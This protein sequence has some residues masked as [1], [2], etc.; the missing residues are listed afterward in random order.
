MTVCVVGLGKI[1]LPLSLQVAGAGKRVI[2]ADR[3]PRVVG[4]VLESR[5]PFPGE[6]GLAERLSDAVQGGLL[7]ATTDTAAAVAE[8]N[9]VIV[10]VPLVIG[11]DF[12]PDFGALDG[13]TSDVARGMRPGT[14]VSY[15]TT[16]P[17]GTT[18]GRLAPRLAAESGLEH[19]RQFDVCHSPE[20]VSSGRVFA[21]LRRYPKL[22]G[23]LDSAGGDRAA[24]FYASVLQFD[25]RPDL[26]RPNGV[27]DLGSAEAAEL[28]KLAETSYRNVNIAFANE[29]AMI[30]DLADVDLREVILAA[31]SQPYSHIH[32]PGV[33]VG[34]HCIPVYPHFLLSGFPGSHLIRSTL[35]VNAGMPDYAVELLSGMLGGLEGARVTVLGATYRGG[36]KESAFS[37]V[38][39][40]VD[41][42]QKRGA[43]VTVHDPLYSE[44]EFRDLGLEAYERGSAADGAIVQSDHDQYRNWGPA[45]LPG[46]RAVVDGRGILETVRWPGVSLRRIGGGHETI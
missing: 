41:S 14:L 10:V 19:G 13:A 46:I 18:R 9:V 4:Q 5:E 8:S 16:L 6:P 28:A 39:P 43:M 35:E 17:L 23:G 25:E 21:D 26:P 36:V 40:V 12:A 34:G 45:D 24:E 29:L 2:G 1:G 44:E 15:E 37:G 31:N 30:A 27:W 22:V 38:F 42:L 3:D 20:R 32:A 11:A 7:T 33:A